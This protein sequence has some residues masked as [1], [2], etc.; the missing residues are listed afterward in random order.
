MKPPRRGDSVFSSLRGRGEDQV[1]IAVGSSK[2]FWRGTT[3]H[4]VQLEESRYVLKVP[5]TECFLVH[6]AWK[7]RSDSRDRKVTERRPCNTRCLGG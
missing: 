7:M 6:N 1:H 5:V 2:L 3:V 4:E